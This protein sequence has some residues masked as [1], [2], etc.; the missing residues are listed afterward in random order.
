MSSAKDFFSDD[1]VREISAAIGVAETKTSGEVRVHIEKKCE[2]DALAEAEMWFGK[3]G[4]HKTQDRNGILIYLAVESRVFAVYGDRGIHEKVHQ[5]FWNE[6]THNME[7]KFRDGK[8]T[9]G[10]VEMINRTGEQ[11]QKYFPISSNDK[12]E[13]SNDI[14]FR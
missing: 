14:S 1:Q 11:L 7:L 13:L 8:F 4:M 5:E 10:L 12:N 6:V 3:L 9:D 2:R